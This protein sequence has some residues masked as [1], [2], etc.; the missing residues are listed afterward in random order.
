M[1]NIN[2]EWGILAT[3]LGLVMVLLIFGSALWFISSAGRSNKRFRWL[4]R[5]RRRFGRQEPNRAKDA[6]EAGD[7]RY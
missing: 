1:D 2:N 4:Q 6:G 3:V 7:R 5:V